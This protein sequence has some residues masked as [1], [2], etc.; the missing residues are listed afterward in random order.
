VFFK[1]SID[2]GIVDENENENHE[3]EKNLNAK[4]GYRTLEKYHT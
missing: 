1:Y 4:Y 3:S 2:N